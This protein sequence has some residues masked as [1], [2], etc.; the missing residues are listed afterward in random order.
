M[1]QDPELLSALLAY[2]DAISPESR[3]ELVGYGR[4]LRSTGDAHSPKARA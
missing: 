1:H 2:W 4:R 3:L